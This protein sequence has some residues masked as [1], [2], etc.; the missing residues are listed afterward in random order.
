MLEP[1]S[2]ADLRQTTEALVRIPSVSRDRPRCH[3]VLDAI[4]ASVPEWDSFHSEVFEHEGYKSLIVGTRPGRAAPLILNGHV[5]VVTAHQHQFSPEMRQDGLLWG[6]GVY[7]MKGAVAVFVE[8]LKKLSAVPVADRPHLQVQFVSDEEIGGHRGVER[9]VEEGF[10]TDLFLAGEPTDLDICNQAKG[11]LWMRYK[12]SGHPGHSARPW[13]CRNP[14]AG[15]AR[16]LHQIYGRFPVPVQPVWETTATVTGID[17]GENAH[18]RVPDQAFCKIDCRYVPQDDPQELIR[19]FRAVMP[20]S[21]LEI[22]QLAVCLHTAEDH[23]KLQA[24]MDVGER[25]LG[26]RPGLFSE[27]FASDARY[28]SARGTPALCWGPSGG[29]MHADDERLDLESLASYARLIDALV[30]ELAR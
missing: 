3:E 19:W 12:L 7:D 21:E 1:T 15:L 16:G 25:V 27:H 23:P 20:D 22:V 9:M 4:R 18:N 26:R 13:L 14:L 5:D 6:R 11:V 28:Y 24:C 2:L 8:L 10:D 29:G 17:V 30:L